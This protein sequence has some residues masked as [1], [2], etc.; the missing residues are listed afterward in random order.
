MFVCYLNLSTQEKFAKRALNQC[1]NNITQFSTLGFFFLG[2]LLDIVLIAA[3]V[4]GPADGSH[5]IIRWGSKICRCC[6][7][8]SQK[9]L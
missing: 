6:I 4:V 5:Y 9:F 3:Q 8:L 1:P 7:K 2:H